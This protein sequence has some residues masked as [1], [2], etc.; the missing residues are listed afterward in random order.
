MYC[1]LLVDARNKQEEERNAQVKFLY[2]IGDI[3]KKLK[4]KCNIK[5]ISIVLV[6]C[7]I[8]WKI[9]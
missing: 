5:I 7:L 1:E 8:I 2:K 6:I 4:T 3:G 9:M